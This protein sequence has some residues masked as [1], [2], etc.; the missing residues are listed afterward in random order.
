MVRIEKIT[1]QGFKS[2]K[3]KTSI[4]IL[5]GFTIFTG[6]N[7]SG[8]CLDYN[9]LV[10]MEGGSLVKIGELVESK[11]KTGIIKTI[12]DGIIIE[13]SGKKVLSV[14]IET[15]K[16]EK[17]PVQ[18][19]IKRKSP[20]SMIKLKTRSGRSLIATEYHPLFVLNK[21]RIESVTAENI[22]E[23]LKIAV[24]RRLGI[25][26]ET[27][28]FYE[29]LDFEP[30]DNIYVPR[31]PAL[32]HQTKALIKNKGL[33]M[34]QVAE[35]SN[36]P[37]ERLKG[38]LNGQA[39]NFA[40]FVRLQRLLG[41]S[42]DDIIG[43]VS[44]FKSSSGKVSY[45]MLWENSPE[46]SRFLGYLI[47]EGRLSDTNQIWFTN[48]DQEIVEDYVNIAR[49]LFGVEPSIN[50][51]K[52]NVWDVLIYSKPLIKILEKFGMANKTG[53]KELKNIF[54]SHSSDKELAEFL[55]GLYSGDGYVSKSSVEITTKSRKLAFNIKNILLRLGILFTSRDVIKVA[56]NTGFSGVYEQISVYGDNIRLFREN[57]DLVH[58]GKRER[59]EKICDVKK[60]PNIDLIEAN[61]LIKQVVKDL[62]I[63]VKKSKQKF[64]R[65]DAY[66]YNQ[67]TPSIHGINHLISNVFLQAA[68]KTGN[69]PQ[70]LA[71]LETLVT[72]DIYWD[73]IISVEKVPPGEWIYDLT[74]EKD[75]NFI[76]NNIIVHNSNIS[77]S[78]AFVLGEGS[79]S[80]RAKKAEQLVFHGSEK[81]SGAD[82]AKVSIHFDNSSKLIPI[83]ER[84]VII[85]RKLNNKG[86]STYKLNGKTVNRQHFL[87]IFTQARIQTG[88]HNMIRQGDVTHIVEMNPVERRRIIDEISG[89]A[90]YDDKKTKAQKELDQVNEKLKEAEIIL[91]EK[92]QIF[93]RIKAD[94]DA[95]VKY[96]ELQ[97]ELDLT[98]ASLIFEEKESLTKDLEAINSKI[99]E[100]EKES[101]DLEKAIKEADSELDKEEKILEDIT[102]KA[103]NVSGEIE[104]V[105]KISKLESEI[106]RKR[107]RIQSNE[108]E[109][110][111]ISE[112]STMRGGE[113]HFIDQLKRMGGVEGVV[114]G[115]V[116]IPSKYRVAAEVAAGG[117]FND[118]VVDSLNTAVKCVNYLKSNRLGKARF[119]PLDKLKSPFRQ[120]APQGTL[121]L[122]SDLVKCDNKYGKVVDYVFGT[123][124]CVGTI[125]NAKS[126]FTRDRCRMVTLDGDLLEKSGAVTGG[127]NKKYSFSDNTEKLRRE[128]SLFED[129]IAKLEDELSKL[130]KKETKTPQA[131]VKEVRF[132]HRMKKTRE[133]RKEAYEQKLNVLQKINENNIRRAKIEATLDNLKIQW[134]KYEKNKTKIKK[135]K[136][137]ELRDRQRWL[138]KE[139]EAIGPVNMKAIDEFNS[140]KDEF[141]DFRVKFD[142]IV[143]ERQS[144]E[145]VVKEIEEKRSVVFGA[146]FDKVNKNFKEVWAELTNGKGELH[147]E[148][149]KNID[150]GLLIVASPSGKRLLNIDSMSGGEKT[151]TALAFLFAVQRYKPSP[152][153]ILDEADAAL[154][155]MNTKKFA[156]MLK[157]Q[158][159]YA[160][161]LLVSHNDEMI[162]SADQ[163]YGLSMEDGESKIIGVKLPEEN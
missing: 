25:E 141:S 16:I 129:D 5:S 160:Q 134:E 78:L 41:Y 52:P 96:Q 130:R 131:E 123:T 1:I 58:K 112:I 17:R 83:D 107:D 51:Y 79:R 61:D 4:P 47:A 93:E 110:S 19:Y 70:S 80:L 44:R 137:I 113:P 22:K 53:K 88:G 55:N 50:E 38:F 138:I 163:V 145:G 75:H 157:K 26:P 90:E 13:N 91:N 76:A 66:C 9:S 146:A 54:V 3:N 43:I 154:D 8:K 115:L 161:F 77:E 68:E 7:G 153:Y 64:P 144:I 37:F 135:L 10:Q 119:L 126:I 143:G 89:I 132:D 46:F 12:D 98:R 49:K 40:Y 120:A 74:I 95:A 125:E 30:K 82:Y 56:T 111:R 71:V 29:L 48:G 18:A 147:L 114:S 34:K 94:R 99:A 11:E 45:K 42:D 20:E 31:S 62:G 72:S 6:P 127:F 33:T 97:E 128:N 73:E 124:A 121:G 136:P 149:P 14:D 142:K 59:I 105:R 27:K 86:V 104:L 117:H 100:L 140:F 118:I 87:D 39:I 92:N 36:V 106:E 69:H 152:F 84:E 139:I 57:V 156:D 162:K 148:N 133:K 81:K 21:D 23:G 151:L 108:R 158:A 109:I 150:T 101:L 2:F 63:N 102:T 32:V 24:P 103:M 122:L 116:Q 67:C 155:K 159:K 35:H 60:N 28:T 15:L 65:L 85:T